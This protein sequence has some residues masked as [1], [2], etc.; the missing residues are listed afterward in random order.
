ML[1]IEIAIH[2]QVSRDVSDPSSWSLDF[3]LQVNKLVLYPVQSL[4]E[5]LVNQINLGLSN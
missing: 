5:F 4:L 1:Q 3:S 2:Y